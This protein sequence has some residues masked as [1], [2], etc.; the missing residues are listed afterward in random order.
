ML[1]LIISQNGAQKNKNKNKKKKKEKISSIF[2]WTEKLKG[3]IFLLS[4]LLLFVTAT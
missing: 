2:C 3:V 4:L 1:K